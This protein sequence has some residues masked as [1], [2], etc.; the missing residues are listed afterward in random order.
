MA[1]A[2][3]KGE[4]EIQASDY[5]HTHAQHTLQPR[6]RHVFYILY[7]HLR[8]CSLKEKSMNPPTKGFNSTV[9]LQI[10]FRGNHSIATKPKSTV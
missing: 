4:G 5:T 6:Q 10:C 7:G 1:V 3:G 9:L 8:F 2:Q